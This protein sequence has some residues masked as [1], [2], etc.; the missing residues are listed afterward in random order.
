MS[1]TKKVFDPQLWV[2]QQ[3]EL[4]TN[5]ALKKK[6]AQFALEHQNDSKRQLLDYVITCANEPDDCD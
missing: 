1:E 3:L 6:N 5:A 4:R 2:S